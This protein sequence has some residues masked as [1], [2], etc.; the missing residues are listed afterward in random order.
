MHV[1]QIGCGTI[2]LA[3]AC[4]LADKGVQVTVL[5]KSHAV[6][7]RYMDACDI[8]HVDD[9]G[10]KL[11]R[12]VAAVF[13]AVPTPLLEEHLDFSCLASTLPTVQKIVTAN[14]PAVVVLRRWV[15]TL[16]YSACACLSQG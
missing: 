15:S 10:V 8:F 11:L 4:A 16:N 7:Q 3:Y 1:V 5:E 14:P 2:G 12:E 13:V 6:I 9:E